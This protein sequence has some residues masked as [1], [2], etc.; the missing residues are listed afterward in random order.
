M[1]NPLLTA[2]QGLNSCTVHDRQRFKLHHQ[3]Q[4]MVASQ[5][6]LLCVLQVFQTACRQGHFRLTVHTSSE[7][8]TVDF[9]MHAF[10]VGAAVISL[11]RWLSEL[12]ER[13]PKDGPAMLRQQVSKTNMRVDK[14]EE[15][16]SCK[17]HK[18]RKG[19]RK[20]QSKEE[21]R[22]ERKK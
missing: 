11:M 15:T 18:Q 13:L 17:K 2:I 1:H 19:E 8:G 12:R 10:T 3:L 16:A 21:G 7:S 20:K 6:R 4:N 9:G 14:G 22:N 5:W